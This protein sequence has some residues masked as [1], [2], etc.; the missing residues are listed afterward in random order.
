MR[1][2]NFWQTAGPIVMIV[3]SAILCVILVAQAAPWP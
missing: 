1:S 2:S 3:G